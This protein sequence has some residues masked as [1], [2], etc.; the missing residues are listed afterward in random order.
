MIPELTDAISAFGTSNSAEIAARIAR[1]SEDSLPYSAT[2]KSDSGPLSAQSSPHTAS[3]W[4]T[5]GSTTRRK[6]LAKVGTVAAI[7]M[8]VGFAIGGAWVLGSRNAVHRNAAS[9][10][11]VATS[12]YVVPSESSLAAASASLPTPP[13]LDSTARAAPSAA[14]AAAPVPVAS[15][16]STANKIPVVAASARAEP[17]KSSAPETPKCEAGKAMSNGHCCRVG[18]EWKGNECVPGTAKVFP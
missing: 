1:M 13:S 7:M 16:T 18:F 9:S 17:A 15:A 12:P 6:S 4:G 8:I 11:E 2:V 14:P 5:T 3:A 10:A